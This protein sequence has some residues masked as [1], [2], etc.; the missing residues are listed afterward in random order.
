MPPRA[1]PGH[2][3]SPRRCR[4]LGRRPPA[5]ERGAAP[6]ARVAECKHQSPW[7][8]RQESDRVTS[9]MDDRIRRLGI[10]VT[11]CKDRRCPGYLNRTITNKAANG[12]PPRGLFVRPS[13]A[14]RGKIEIVILGQ[15]PGRASGSERELYRQL[16]RKEPKRLFREIHDATLNAMWAIEYWKRVDDLLE[17]LVPDG[18]RTPM[19]AAELAYCQNA[20]NARHPGGTTI[21][22]CSEKHLVEHLALLSPGKA[23]L[24]VGASARDWFE[25]Y[26]GAAKFRWGWIPHITGSWGTFTEL[27]RSP[28]AA[29]KRWDRIATGKAS[30][31]NLLT[32]RRR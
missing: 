24:C 29:K 2:S 32:G 31:T 13:G 26:D 14:L 4:V 21:A 20:E 18:R 6:S 8:S 3:S 15:N 23:C 17:I 19:L 12:V 16:Y 25:R 22:H 1:R 28:G 9:G 30:G 7:C 5:G 10:A 27:M 11:S